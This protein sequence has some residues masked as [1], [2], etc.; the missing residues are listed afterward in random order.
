MLYGTV[1]SPV[2]EGC[3]YRCTFRSGLNGT[4]GVHLNV[5][6]SPDVIIVTWRLKRVDAPNIC[7]SCFL[8]D[9]SEGWGTSSYPL[10]GA[11]FISTLP[12]GLDSQLLL[13]RLAALGTSFP[14]LCA[15]DLVCDTNTT[16]STL[17]TPL[18]TMYLEVRPLP[19]EAAW[20]FTSPGAFSSGESK[21]RSGGHY[22]LVI[23]GSARNWQE[24]VGG[25]GSS[26]GLWE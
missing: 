6:A 25:K 17:V 21:G 11:C 10:H 15:L 26:T 7:L 4:R 12:G 2:G 20:W 24:A 9:P 16:S 1:W 22:V 19:T 3:E 8:P 18:P 5:N 23:C 14:T 13:T